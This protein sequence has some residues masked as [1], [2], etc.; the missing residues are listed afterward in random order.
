[1]RPLNPKTRKN[2]LCLTKSIPKALKELLTIRGD[3]TT[4]DE[5]I[6]AFSDYEKALKLMKKKKSVIS[7]THNKNTLVFIRSFDY[8][9]L[10]ILKFTILN[11]LS[12]TDF[13]SIPA[14]FFSKYFII[15][16]NIENKRIENFF[17]DFFSQRTVKIDIESVKYA[18]IISSSSKVEYNLKYV[19][20]LNDFSVEDIG[21]SFDLKLEKEFYCGD[22]IY[23]KAF[24]QDK[25]VKQKNVSKNVFKDT[26]GKLHIDRQDLNDINLKKSRAY[27]TNK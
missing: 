2:V 10:E 5:S 24:S 27:K 15:S 26:V 13:N 20:V 11:A 8:Q 17:I 3:F 7:V 18:W 16:Q 22:E 9:P 4:L 19:R 21:P 1:M 6:D 14:E 12:S 25:P 23:S